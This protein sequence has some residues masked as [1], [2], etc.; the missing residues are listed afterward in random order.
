MTTLLRRG[1]GKPGQHHSRHTPP[2]PTWAVHGACRGDWDPN[3]WHP[4]ADSDPT[5]A[6]LAKAICGHCPV[7]LAC[8]R[9]ALANRE[10]WGIWGALDQ[11]ERR[12]L[13]EHQVR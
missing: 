1:R 5:D 12:A 11:N 3:L 7:M 6:I 2:S 4:D 9:H 10:D 13:L 8:R